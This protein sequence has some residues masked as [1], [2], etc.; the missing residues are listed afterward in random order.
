MHLKNLELE[1]FK[2]FVDPTEIKFT[3]GFTAIVGPN[4]CGKSNVSDAIR[5]VIGEQSSKSLRGTRITDLIFNGSAMRKPVN[6]ASISLTLTNVPAGL[7]IANVPNMSEEVKVT[8]CYH[9]SGESEF[10]INQVPCRLKDITDFLLDVGIS[11]KVLTVIEQ[12]HIQD[13]INAKPE[14][15]RI[16]IEEAAGILKFKHRK[17]EALRKLESSRQNLERITDIV[18]ELGRQVESLKRQAAK[19][20]RYKRYQ[21]EI[22]EISLKLFARKTRRFE[23]ELKEIEEQLGQKTEQKTHWAARSSTLENDIFNLNLNIEETVKKLNEMKESIHELSNRIGKNEHGIELKKAQIAQ[24]E[25]AIQEA[26]GE[27][28]RINEEIASLVNE[29]EAQRKELGNISENINVQEMELERHNEEMQKTRQS[30]A[31]L[32]KSIQESD[33]K[34]LEEYHQ[35]AREKNSL[36]ALETRRQTLEARDS[37]LKEEQDQTDEEMEALRSILAAAENEYSRKVEDVE[38]LAARRENLGRETSESKSTLESLNEQLSTLKEKHLAQSSLLSSIKELRNKF[39]GFHE[40]VKSLMSTDLNGDRLAGLREVLVDVLKTPPEYEQAIE[41]VLGEKLQS[42]IVNSYADTVEAIGY[43]KDHHSGRGSFIPMNPKGIPSQ[44]VQLNGNTRVVGKAVDFI[45]C[46]EE[47][48]PIINHLLQ[49]VVMVN[50]LNT[51]VHLHEHPEFNGTVVTLNGEM[52]D[53][54]GLVSGGAVEESPTG[55]LAKNRETEELTQKVSRSQNELQSLQSKVEQQKQAHAELEDSLQ[56]TRKQVHQ[57]ELVKTHNQKDLEQLKKDLQRLE[58]KRSTLDYERSSGKHELEDLL[59]QRE[60]LQQDLS[61]AEAEKE[62]EEESLAIIRKDLEG[63]REKL[64]QKSSELSGI[65]V[66]IASLKGN[67]ETTLTEIKRLD[68]HQE[69]LRQRIQRLETEQ[70]DNHSKIEETGKGV[71]E[72][73]KTI[74]DQVHD[75]D[76]LTGES[77]RED[78]CLNEKDT[79]LKEMEKETRELTK[80]IQELMEEISR[81]EIRRSETRMK[82]THIEEKAYDDFNATRDEMMRYYTEDFDEEEAEERIQELKGKIA[83]M[84]EVNLAALSDFEQINERYTFLKLQQEDLSESIQLLHQ[85]IERINRTTKQRFLETF[86]NVNANFKE[87]FAQ[88]FRGGKAVLTLIDESNPLESGIEITANPLGKTMQN[89]SLLSGGEKSM[90]AIALIFSVFKVRPSPFC[91]LDEVDAPLDEANV[92]RFQEM[93]KEMAMD[94]QFIL[95]TH[96]QRTMSFADVLYGITMEESG[97][98]NAVSVH[99]N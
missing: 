35:I 42:I 62:K 20:E 74:L 96:N 29:V 5:W 39:E 51:A 87:C 4:G 82:I 43:L 40:G 36:T 26:T 81:M 88:L 70:A 37:R 46:K 31:R 72:L 65:M 79:Q 94:T 53:A 68:L 63:C 28:V 22:K 8:R 44:P 77:V 47:Y 73:E 85:T 23:N 18:Q 1:G 84:G 59:G 41:A 93:L 86:A 92:I 78:E 71:E 45:D 32:E 9:R 30:L 52:I 90:T 19:A 7:R 48:R 14:N 49:N 38:S 13:I 64:E 95:I 6:R 80:K 67:R 24:A 60:S 98:S 54:Q 33:Q 66:M 12:G 57:A 17:N 61:V 27:I 21:G 2:S 83:R 50:D 34:V 97:V 58:D 55:L 3:E 10:Y 56:E 91:L 16:L 25:E 15:R 75:K 99:L 76:R 69:N 11:P 89:I